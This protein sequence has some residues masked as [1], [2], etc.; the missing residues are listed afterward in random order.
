MFGLDGSFW[1]YANY[2]DGLHEGSGR[3][4]L[5]GFCEWLVA[6]LGYGN[7][8]VW[9]VLVGRMTFPDESVLSRFRSMTD[10]EDAATVDTLFDSLERFFADQAGSPVGG[11]I[12]D[13]NVRAFCEALSQWIGYD[14]DDS[15]WQAVDSALTGTD[16]D[17]PHAEW[18]V[19]P[20]IGHTRLDL[21]L[22]REAGGAEVSIRIEGPRR[23]ELQSRIDT[24][25]HIM[26]TY[27]VTSP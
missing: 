19:Y 1:S 21:R 20:L 26:S 7:N 13:T 14:F 3:T 17:R 11:W 6:R 9:E 2:L 23:R 27:T 16:A 24:L 22:A 25:F 18:Y 4:A 12:W 5:A 15:D 10:E 8:L